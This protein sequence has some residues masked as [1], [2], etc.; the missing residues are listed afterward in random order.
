MRRGVA[1]A[2]VCSLAVAAAGRPEELPQPPLMAAEALP[3]TETVVA[4]AE[5]PEQ[6]VPNVWGV[7]GLRGAVAGE[8][9]APNGWTYDPVFTLDLDFNLMLLPRHLVYLYFDSRFWAQ[10]AAPGITNER[11]GAFDFSKRQFDLTGGLAWNYWERAEARAFAYSSNNLNRGW[12]PTQPEDFKDGLGLE[13]RWYLNAYYD[14]LG[15]REFD[16]ARA[17]FVSMG[18][19]P[20]K[21]LVGGDGE[22][23]EP[24]LF[25]RAYLTYE[26]PNLRSYL[27]ADVGLYFTDHLQA[28]LLNT[29]V[30]IAVRPFV[31]APRLEFRANLEGMHDLDV[32][33]SRN[34]GELA[35]RVVY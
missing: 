7:A 34:L 26:M 17:A 13:N 22:P 32:G 21:E 23:F 19:L 1:I 28:K 11:Q 10:R 4:D 16:V 15:T 3:A 6:V 2:V 33:E 12:S 18:Y 30:G 9:V 5:V 24:G 20:T 31:R 14:V 8:K 35:V 27:Y 29:D 25:F